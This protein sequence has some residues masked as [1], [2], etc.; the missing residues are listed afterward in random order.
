M[1]VRA[2][3]DLNRVLFEDFDL[4]VKNPT[5]KENASL[6]TYALSLLT[7]KFNPL[8]IFEILEQNSVFFLDL[9]TII[10]NFPINDYE[11]LC[12]LLDFFS[13]LIGIPYID[14]NEFFKIGL[15]ETID[16]LLKEPSHEK[17]KKTALEIL[18]SI[19]FES[20]PSSNYEGEIF[21]FLQKRFKEIILGHNTIVILKKK[22]KI[23]FIQVKK[24]LIATLNTILENGDLT[25]QKIINFFNDKEILHKFLELF[26]EDDIK[27]QENA[28]ELIENILIIG[29]NEMAHLSLSTNPLALKI[30]QDDLFKN[31]EALQASKNEKIAEIANKLYDSYFENM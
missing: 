29:V 10:D 22:I 7:K 1:K 19:P 16:F 30:F 20:N 23:Y 15:L 11:F 4:V 9:L 14:P 2:L 28:L 5:N 18:N 27:M 25:D 13:D 12:P 17:V 31:I 21:S 3:V 26:E 8:L 6:L 24:Q